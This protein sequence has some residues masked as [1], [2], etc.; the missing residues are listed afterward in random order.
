MEVLI[1]AGYF[2]FR[3]FASNVGNWRGRNGLNRVL[4]AG[5]DEVREAP[6]P[7]C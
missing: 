4:E 2:G 5:A 7:G 1:L 6:L 3:R